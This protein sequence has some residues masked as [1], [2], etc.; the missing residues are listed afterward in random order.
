MC[1]GAGVMVCLGQGTGR[2]P[3]GLERDPRPEQ[4]VISGKVK[5]VGGEQCAWAL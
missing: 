2:R 4:E 5:A 3:V 1:K